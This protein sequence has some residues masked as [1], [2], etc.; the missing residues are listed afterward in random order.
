MMA[1]LDT[2]SVARCSWAE[3]DP[4]MRAYHDMMRFII[5][6]DIAPEVGSVVPM[7]EAREAIGE[8]VEGRTHGETRFTR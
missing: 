8:M 2:A 6:N 7:N 3:G 4:L 5:A 1:A